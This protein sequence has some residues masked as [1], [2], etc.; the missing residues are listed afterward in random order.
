MYPN[1]N[2][3]SRFA[4]CLQKIQETRYKCPNKFQ[5]SS[6]K[7]QINYKF[8]GPNNQNYLAVCDLEFRTLRFICYLGFGSWDLLFL[9]LVFCLPASGRV[10][11]SFQVSRHLHIQIY[12][13]P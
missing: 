6:T 5:I 8:Q 10:I 7:H 11:V 3:K 9:F 12:L 4:V 13:I 1:H 2:K